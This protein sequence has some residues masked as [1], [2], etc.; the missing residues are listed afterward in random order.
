[1]LEVVKF[2]DIAIG[3]EL[4]VVDTVNGVVTTCHGQVTDLHN[5]YGEEEV[6]LNAAYS[7][8]LYADG[9]PLVALRI[10]KTDE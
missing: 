9:D 4:V 2:D 3:D 6:V 1:M 8:E 7:L 10:T 5:D